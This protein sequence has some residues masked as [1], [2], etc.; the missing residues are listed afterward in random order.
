MLFRRKKNN[1]DKERTYWETIGLVAS[2]IIVILIYWRWFLPGAITW[3]DWGYYT[4]GSFS[5]IAP[6][7]WGGGLGGDQISGVA[8]APLIIISAFLARTFDWS[9]SIVERVTC[10]FPLILYLIF[11]QY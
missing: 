1:L 5:D 4:K 2:V 10:F 8:Y 11:S 3:G 6:G 7:L 9:Y